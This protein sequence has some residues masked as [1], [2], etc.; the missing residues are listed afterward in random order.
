MDFDQYYDEKEA[1]ERRHREELHQLQKRYALANCKVQPGDI[2]TN[3]K[4]TIKVKR[5]TVYV[6]VDKK[7]GFY[8]TG[9]VVNDKGQV[10]QTRT[11]TIFQ[12]ELTQASNG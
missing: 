3:G 5:R 4:H 11:E 2:V 6:N 7:P 12:H 10:V 1:L 9:N 8:F